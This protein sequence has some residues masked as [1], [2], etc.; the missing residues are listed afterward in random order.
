MM[1]IDIADLVSWAL[2]DQKAA[3]FCELS[4][5][6]RKALVSSTAIVTGALALGVQV[7]CQP[8]SLK[9]MAARCHP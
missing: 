2:G 4:N 7:D 9:C 5:D 6:S 8:G 3:Y 1:E